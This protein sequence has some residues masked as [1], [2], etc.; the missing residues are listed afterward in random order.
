MLTLY[1]RY[2]NCISATKIQ[3]SYFRDMVSYY[4]I[5]LTVTC[6]VPHFPLFLMQLVDLVTVWFQQC[7][8]NCCSS[9]A[10]GTKFHFPCTL[11]SIGTFWSKEHIFGCGV[12]DYDI[13]VPNAL[14][15]PTPS[16]L[17]YILQRQQISLKCW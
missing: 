10:A 16:S 14:E 7:N 12:V 15:E 1:T 5:I 6:P 9:I 13:A 17:T 8:I 11:H 3:H 2:F 4:V